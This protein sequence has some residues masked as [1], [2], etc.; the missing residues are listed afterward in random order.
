MAGLYKNKITLLCDKKSHEF[1]ISYSKK[2]NSLG[3]AECR[4]EERE[5][6]KEQ[7]KQQEI[8]RNQEYLKKQQELFIKA[9]QEMEHEETNTT[10]TNTNT[11]A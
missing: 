5:E 10:N 4:K 7:L 6:W 1:T 2:L 11:G 9:R 8:L 3:C